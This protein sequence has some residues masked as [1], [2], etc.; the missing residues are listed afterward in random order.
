MSPPLPKVTVSRTNTLFRT[1]SFAFM[2]I[3]TNTGARKALRRASVSHTG[4]LPSKR[5][6]PA[7]AIL[8]SPNIVI[9]TSMPI[10]AVIVR[11]LLP[12]G[13]SMRRAA[14]LTAAAMPMITVTATITT[15][16]IAEPDG[17]RPS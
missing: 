8:F 10:R 7:P 4:M 17:L 1:D 14:M 12:V 2:T 16:A 11:L 13:R 3:R 15:T 6:K 5:D 9:I